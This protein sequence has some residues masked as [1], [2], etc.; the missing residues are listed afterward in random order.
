M[1]PTNLPIQS[2]VDLFAKSLAT[3]RNL[4]DLY[5]KPRP[6][7]SPTKP[8]RAV[9]PAVV[10]A[11]TAAFEAFAEELVVICL[12]KAGES[13][14]QIAKSA[15]LTNPTLT[16]LCRTLKHAAGIAILDPSVSSGPWHLNLWHKTSTTAWYPSRKL[17][18]DQVLEESEGW[19]QVRHCLTHGLATGTEPARWPGPVTGKA[20][21]NRSSL[22]TASSVLANSTG[23]RHS[24]TL[25]PAINCG[26]V[27]SRGGAEIARQVAA[28]FGEPVDVSGLHLFEDV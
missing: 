26:L 27:Y 9:P 3:P 17:P 11:V 16:D 12:L 5:P 4:F 19:M 15:D 24:L 28:V 14:A 10:Q 22:R 13:W 7:S 25:Y 1:V 21:A 8:L 20:H 6:Q 23:G 2:A 18:W